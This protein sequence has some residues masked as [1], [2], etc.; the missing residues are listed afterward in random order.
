MKHLSLLMILLFSWAW[1]QE[2]QESR[3]SIQFH[4]GEPWY[5][6]YSHKLKGNR[7]VYLS[8]GAGMMGMFYQ[9]DYNE[10]YINH[11]GM[12]YGRSD[13]IVGNF[14]I[15]KYLALSQ[16]KRY[17][18]IVQSGIQIRYLPWMIIFMPNDP[19]MRVPKDPGYEILP[20]I[21]GGIYYKPCHFL[22]SGILMGP[23]I[24]IYNIPGT[25]DLLWSLYLGYRF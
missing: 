7:N 2:T 18:L 25:T 23:G 20:F 24:N 4:A 3:N 6:N 19:L 22:E 13:I 14:A 9:P 10:R 11:S 21:Q 16:N 15:R 8:M 1:A 12:Y 5:V 17:G